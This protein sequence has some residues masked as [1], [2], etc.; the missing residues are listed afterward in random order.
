MNFQLSAAL[1]TVSASIGLPM[2]A[3]LPA[4]AV[5]VTI[6][7]NSYDVTVFTGSYSSN[8]SLFQALTPG[9]MPWWGDTTGDTAYEFAVQVFDQLGSGPTTDYGPV[10]AYDISAG[11]VVGITQS[12][13]NLAAQNVETIALNDSVA[14]A[15]ATPLGP[16]PNQVPA[17]LPVFGAMAAFGCSRKLRKRILGRQAFQ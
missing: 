14:Y 11:G 16:P 12:L 15:I 9:Q 2:L 3:A 17:P 13:T 1:F 6:G 5:N 10:F 8:T 7:G 4:A